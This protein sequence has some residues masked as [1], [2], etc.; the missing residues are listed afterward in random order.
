MKLRVLIVDDERLARVSLRKILSLREDV[1]IVGEAS[2]VSTAV[3]K[4]TELSP[5][6]VFLDIQLPDGLGF[7]IFNR[8]EVAAHVIF[9]TA[10]SQH[11]L[12]AF[13]VN[14]LD[15]LMKPIDPAHIDRALHRASLPQKPETAKQPKS[16]AYTMEDTICLQESGR[17]KFT[18][19]RDIV[20][21]CAADDYVEVHLQQGAVV[22]VNERLHRWESLLPEN[23][24]RTHRSTLVNMDYIEEIGHAE[25]NW[26]IRLRGK[27]QPLVMSRRYA[28]SLKKRLKLV[29]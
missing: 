18:R 8:I 27:E 12:R 15:Y 10:Y 28:Q 19:V 25:G 7:D 16:T 3:E 1:E 9:V 4:I 22:L 29:G 17:M 23:F 13:E 26:Q 6:L 24:A 11:A 21:I 20:Y 14:A 2:S 5:D